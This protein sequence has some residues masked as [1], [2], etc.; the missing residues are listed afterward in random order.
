M[1]Y[2]FWFKLS[3]L[4]SASTTFSVAALTCC[5]ALILS[6]SS[7]TPSSMA[8]RWR[9][10]FSSSSSCSR[11]SCSSTQVSSSCRIWWRALNSPLTRACRSAP[12]LCDGE[13][14]TDVTGSCRSQTVYFACVVYYWSRLHVHLVI[15]TS[16]T[17]HRGVASLY[18]PVHFV[19]CTLDKEE[20]GPGSDIFCWPSSSTKHELEWLNQYNDDKIVILSFC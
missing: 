20:G 15:F 19:R 10:T 6:S 9:W 18:L 12:T 2:I 13:K 1:I 16:G 4:T 5:S 7:L 17:W 11:R 3:V 14:T 8:S